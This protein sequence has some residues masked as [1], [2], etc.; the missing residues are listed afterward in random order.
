MHQKSMLQSLYANFL[1]YEVWTVEGFTPFRTIFNSHHP[2]SDMDNLLFA[3][4]TGKHLL[5]KQKKLKKRILIQWRKSGGERRMSSPM[6]H[7][8]IGPPTG[9]FDHPVVMLRQ[10]VIIRMKQVERVDTYGNLWLGMTK[11]QKNIF[12]FRIAPFSF[13]TCGLKLFV[14]QASWRSLL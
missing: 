14:S 9:S 11:V 13:K 5:N 4:G 2:Y 10:W 3:A 12:F 7:V 1:K 6:V 8:P